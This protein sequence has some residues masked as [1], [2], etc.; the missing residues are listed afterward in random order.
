M[1]KICFESDGGV[2]LSWIVGKTKYS[3]DVTFG[4][5]FFEIGLFFS[6]S[7]EYPSPKLRKLPKL[8]ILIG[9]F[10]QMTPNYDGI[11]WLT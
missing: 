5:V 11:A 7:F 10:S 8:T 9:P 3:L 4:G 2:G 1:V 6:E